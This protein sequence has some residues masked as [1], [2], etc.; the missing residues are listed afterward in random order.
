ML[1]SFFLIKRK[2]KIIILIIILIFYINTCSAKHFIKLDN[3]CFNNIT[4][5]EKYFFKKRIQDYFGNKIHKKFLFKIIKILYNNSFYQIFLSKKYFFEKYYL[6]FLRNK[7]ISN[8]YIIGNYLFSKEFLLKKLESFGVKKGSYLFFLNFLRFKNFI[9]NKYKNVGKYLAKIKLIQVSDKKNLVTLL[10]NIQENNVLKIKKIYIYGVDDLIKKNFFMLL[11]KQNTLYNFFYNKNLTINELL[12]KLLNIKIYYISSGYLNFFY[13]KIIIKYLNNKYFDVYVYVDKGVRYKI[14]NVYFLPKKLSN[15]IFLNKL[16]K[17][18]ILNNKFYNINNIKKFKQDVVSYFQKRG[19]FDVTINVVNKKVGKYINLLFKLNIGHIYLINKIYFKINN[20]LL[21][22]KYFF[23]DFFNLEGQVFNSYIIELNKKILNKSGFFKDIT[24]DYKKISFN[25]INVIYNLKLINIKNINFGLNFDRNNKINLSFLYNQNNFLKL[26][27]YLNFGGFLYKNYNSGFLS[28]VY[29][30]NYKRNL[31]VDSKI[32]FNLFIQ[33]NIKKQLNVHNFLNVENSFF[34]L[35]HN[36]LKYR[37]GLGY[38]YK[39]L[40]LN[41]N[42][43]EKDK[44]YIKNIQFN[45]H[46]FFLKNIISL[47]TLDNYIFH[48]SGYNINITNQLVFKNNNFKYNFYKNKFLFSKYFTLNKSHSWILF[49]RSFWGYIHNLQKNTFPFYES[50]V[51]NENN[52][53]HNF[54]LNY[55]NKKSVL[56]LKKNKFNIIHN[57]IRNNIFC[58]NTEL[59]LPDKLFFFKKQFEY[60]RLS[61][62]LDC[63]SIWN[64]YFPIIKEK[65]NFLFK[66]NQYLTEIFKNFR[67]SL[68]VSFKI[69]TPLGILDISYGYPIVKSNT[70]KFNN[71]QFRITSV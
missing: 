16:K 27:D 4:L 47:N 44:F 5:K 70:D 24:I 50:F 37:L 46:N 33:N 36:N 41:F 64:N 22:S 20:N 19:F 12:N 15:I 28:F 9:I 57:L 21:Q 2:I 23:K 63:A 29:P 66:N 26:G 39:K 32:R 25:K 17:I 58:F 43:F 49:V 38:S 1:K 8:I 31:F 61:F 18:F 67:S 35:L 59:I 42:F 51:Y 53:L 65:H 6:Y 11:K 14:L 34:Y 45:V 3:L 68:G 7:K 10:I 69:H 30:I 13:K 40:F 52:F 55:L 62:Y 54:D 60:F 71:F 56:F 48:V